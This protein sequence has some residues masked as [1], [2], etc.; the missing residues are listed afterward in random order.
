MCLPELANG[1]FGKIINLGKI[2]R[3]FLR[4]DEKSRNKSR[5]K[6]VTPRGI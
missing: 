3:H 2:G 5:N 6:K 1:Q 4:V